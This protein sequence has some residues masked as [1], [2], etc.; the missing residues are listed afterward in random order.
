ML[1]RGH[2]ALEFLHT[3]VITDTRHLQAADALVTTHP[4]VEVDAVPGGEDRHLVVHRVE[5]KIRRVRGGAHIG[6]DGRLVDAD[7]VVPAAFDQ[8][9]RHRGTHDATLANDDDLGAFRE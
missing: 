3:L 2:A 5:A 7:D 9:M 6:G 8:V 4:V 1:A